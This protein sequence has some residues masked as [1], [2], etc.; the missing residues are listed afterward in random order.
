MKLSAVGE[1]SVLLLCDVGVEKNIRVYCPGRRT[2]RGKNIG[3]F[4]GTQKAYFP[5][6][7]FIMI[8]TRKR[9]GIITCDRRFP[10]YIHTKEQKT[11]IFIGISPAC[12]YPL[13]YTVDHSYHKVLTYVEYR[14]V[15]G[16]F[17]N[18]D[19]PPPSPPSECVDWHLPV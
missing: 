1:S 16:V 13:T 7:C 14:A 18:I 11:N 5:P 6:A 15:S 2:Y 9:M 4:P 19:S 10:T 3:S 12:S 17:Q 8:N